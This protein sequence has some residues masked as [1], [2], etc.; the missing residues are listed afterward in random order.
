MDA[1]DKSALKRICMNAH[2]KSGKGKI[3]GAEVHNVVLNQEELQFKRNWAYNP[4]KV[5]VVSYRYRGKE[6][7]INLGL[8]PD[9]VYYLRRSD[10]YVGR[11][12][13]QTPVCESPA[14]ISAK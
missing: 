9:C 13:L 14:V 11:F 4:V 5:D 8:T 7:H 3:E 10:R 6:F 1:N 12:R 2:V